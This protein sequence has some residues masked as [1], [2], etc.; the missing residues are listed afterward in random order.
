MTTKELIITALRIAEV[1]R[2]GFSAHDAIRVREGIENGS[3]TVN[4]LKEE[5]ECSLPP[6]GWACSRPLG[7]EGPCAATKGGRLVRFAKA[8]K[9]MSE[10]EE[11]AKSERVREEDIGRAGVMDSAFMREIGKP[12]NHN[13]P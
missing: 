3:I 7:H 6:A 13:K 8:R 4:D 12:G 11:E 9:P 1:H 10:I 2:S 5:N